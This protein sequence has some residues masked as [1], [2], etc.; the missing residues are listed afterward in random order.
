MRMPDVNILV[1]AHRE[2]AAHHE[3]SR[4]W[5]EAA[6]AGAETLGVSDT[7]LSGFVRVV[8]HPR[9]FQTPSPLDLALDFAERLRSSPSAVRV[10]PGERHWSIFTDLCRRANAKGN[11]VPD[12]WLAALAIETGGEWITTDREFARFPGL[13]WKSLL[14]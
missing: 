12:A 8:T 6:M 9:V 11:L 1:Y 2:D 7:V 10:S 3:R 14:P 5:L 13:R 4:A